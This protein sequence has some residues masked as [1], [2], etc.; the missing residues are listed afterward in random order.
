MLRVRNLSK[1]I[2]GA[3]VL[4]NISLDVSAGEVVCLYG[5]NGSGKST[6]MRVIAGLDRP[7]CGKIIMKDRDITTSP[8]WERVAAGVAYAFQIPRPFRSLTF[9]ENLAVPAMVDK[10]KK[11]ALRLAQS[12]VERYGVQHL[13]GRKPDNLS[14]GEVKILEIL[15]AYMTGAEVLLL[16]E[17]FASLDT[18]NARFLRE[19]LVEMKKEGVAMLVTSHRRR[20][21]ESIADRFLRLEGGVVHAEG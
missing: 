20:I 3:V 15:K 10:G 16:D 5:P 6:L 17:P 14:Q 8:P 2:D 21:L 9:I 1:R 13:A 12:V 4:R 7:D 11:E 18:E 19:K